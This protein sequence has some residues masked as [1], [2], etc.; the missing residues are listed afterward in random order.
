MK[1]LYNC[2]H[3]F[4]GIVHSGFGSINNPGLIRRGTPAEQDTKLYVTGS[5]VLGYVQDFGVR[6]WPSQKVVHGTE[7]L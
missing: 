6:G 2:S 5:G 1:V 7:T 3:S 4:S